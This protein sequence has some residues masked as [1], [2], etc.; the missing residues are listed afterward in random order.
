VYADGKFERPSATD[1]QTH[2]DRGSDGHETSRQEHDHHTDATLYAAAAR[3]TDAAASTSTDHQQHD[4]T[5]DEQGGA[6]TT[7]GQTNVD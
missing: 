2:V 4:S 1:G 6:S 5:G 3:W 7:D